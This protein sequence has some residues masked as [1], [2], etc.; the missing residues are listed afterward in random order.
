MIG[1]VL[2]QSQKFQ[3][4]IIQYRFFCCFLLIFF[5]ERIRDDCESEAMFVRE[6]C[7]IHYFKYTSVESN[8]IETLLLNLMARFFDLG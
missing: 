4:L 3:L 2:L 1:G 8:K 6:S 7:L 5:Q